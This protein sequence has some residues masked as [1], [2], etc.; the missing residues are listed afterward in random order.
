MIYIL[1]YSTDAKLWELYGMFLIMGNAGLISSTV[2]YIY[3]Y[4]LPLGKFRDP[5]TAHQKASLR[6]QAPL[7]AKKKMKR[8]RDQGLQFRRGF[9][10]QGL[11]FR[12][13]A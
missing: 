1:H 8:L 10:I 12:V 4:I 9:R 6:L 7:P 13:R 3:I 5:E 11:G 2:V